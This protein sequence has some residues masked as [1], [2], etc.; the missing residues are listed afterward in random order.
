MNVIKYDHPSGITIDLITHAKTP[1][2]CYS[3]LHLQAVVA[4]RLSRTDGIR[5]EQSVG[6]SGLYQSDVTE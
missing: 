4:Y 2:S 6:L 3:L 1:Q 5:L